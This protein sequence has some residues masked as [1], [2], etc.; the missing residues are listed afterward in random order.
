MRRNPRNGKKQESILKGCRIDPPE[1]PLLPETAT[2]I[3]SPAT[4]PC[5]I[6]SAEKTG[7]RTQSKIGGEV[8][9]G[10]SLSHHR[11]LGAIER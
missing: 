5:H 10:P 3:F 11:A 8:L 9:S 1:V 7:L 4:A 2:M 6:S